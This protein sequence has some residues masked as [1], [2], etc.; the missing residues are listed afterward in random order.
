MKIDI[1]VLITFGTIA[2]LSISIPDLYLS[3]I[4]GKIHDYQPQREDFIASSY[5]VD[6]PKFWLKIFMEMMVILLVLVF[7]VFSRHYVFK[8]ALAILVGFMVTCAWFTLK[9]LNKEIRVE[10][11]RVNFYCNRRLVRSHD[12]NDL[13][14]V[15]IKS[16]FPGRYLAYYYLEFG[17]KKRL[18]LNPNFENW[19]QLVALALAVLS[20]KT[21][22]D[23]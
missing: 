3:R 12:L 18:Y 20:K 2:F 4:S 13:E 14:L 6:L 9:I 19:Y 7:I 1:L 15:G 10:D 8:F 22:I 23:K 16:L 17:D 5:K 21:N 11:S